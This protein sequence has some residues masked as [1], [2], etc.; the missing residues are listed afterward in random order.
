[1]KKAKIVATL[2]PSSADKIEDMIKAG[3]D[4]FRLNFSHA[5]HKTHKASIKKIRET[6]K[7]TEFKNGNFAGYFRT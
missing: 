4:V 7:K 6:A 1:M 3:V 2:G 5:D